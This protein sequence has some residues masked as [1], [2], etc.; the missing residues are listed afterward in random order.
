MHEHALIHNIV[1]EILDREK[2]PPGSKVLR[3]GIRIGMLEMHSEAA[4]RQGFEVACRDTPLQGAALDLDLAYP[5]LECPSCGLKKQCAEG[6]ADPH[7]A[8]PVRE[9]PSCKNLAAVRGGRGVGEIRLTL[10]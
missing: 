10:E 3:V 7:D 8:L 1:K 2:L 6:D 5:T 9:C 4:F